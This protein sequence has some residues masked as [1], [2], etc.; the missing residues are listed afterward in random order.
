M[1]PPLSPEKLAKYEQRITPMSLLG[2]IKLVDSFWIFHFCE[3]IL[4]SMTERLQ[5]N[6][7]KMQI[8][9]EEAQNFGNC[10]ENS[11]KV[12]YQTRIWHKKTQQEKFFFC[13]FEE[14]SKIQKTNK[15]NFHRVSLCHIKEK[16]SQ[17]HSHVQN[18]LGHMPHLE[19]V[20]AIKNKILSNPVCQL[21]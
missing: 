4:Y 13:E 9:P 7:N 1:D 18:V 2:D 5:K 3:N 16:L 8:T 14:Y 10:T 11:F 6:S 21:T 12:E 19:T 15:Q 17:L 20:V